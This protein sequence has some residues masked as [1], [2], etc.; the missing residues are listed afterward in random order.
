MGR[1]F[2]RCAALGLTNIKPRLVIGQDSFA[3]ALQ[4][5]KLAAPQGPAEDSQDAQHQQG[6]DR[7][8]QVEAFQSRQ[9]F[10]RRARKAFRITNSELLAMPR[11]AAQ[12][13][14]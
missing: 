13:G 4:V 6:R 1:F 14:K 11:P 12:G 3:L 7:N 10:Q 9:A 2:L 5:F 8:E